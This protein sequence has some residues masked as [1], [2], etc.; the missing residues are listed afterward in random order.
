VENLLVAGECASSALR[1][2]SMVGSMAMG[3]AAGTAAALCAAS[4]AKP[5][6]IDMR[7]L[8]ATLRAQ[9]QVLA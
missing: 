1:V 5:R 4:G 2:R 7:K 8:Q 9:G 6:E 3:H